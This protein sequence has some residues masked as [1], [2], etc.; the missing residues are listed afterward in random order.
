MHTLIF[1]GAEIFLSFL[2]S[3][4]QVQGLA[5]NLPFWTAHTSIVG[6][7]E[8]G[9]IR[10]RLAFSSESVEELLI[11]ADNFFA[12]LELTVIFRS[13]RTIFAL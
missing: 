7:N 2:A 6:V 3:D 4:A 8:V 5:V 12:S 10:T 9:S 13:N 11:R 1:I